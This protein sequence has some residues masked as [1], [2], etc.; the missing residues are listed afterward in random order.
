MH[1]HMQHTQM[2]WFLMQFPP[3]P[4]NKL[5]LKCHRHPS[6][7]QNRISIN[8]LHP[9]V[10]ASDCFTSW[11]TPYGIARMNSE[12]S[13]FPPELII[14]KCLVMDHC[15]LPNTLN[16]YP[17]SLSHFTRFCDDFKVPEADHMPASK[18]LLSM[19]VTTYGAGTVGKGM[20]KTWVL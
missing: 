3:L 20:I 10:L 7:P 18:A 6:N 1:M 15:V 19:F 2:G 12:T 5:H 13:L 9:H 16:N 14:H 11:L 17:T 4:L 8:P